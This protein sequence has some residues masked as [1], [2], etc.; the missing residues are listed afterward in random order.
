MAL[1][2]LALYVLWAG[3][4]STPLDAD[5]TL[6][7][8]S[9]GRTS[10]VSVA[11]PFHGDGVSPYRFGPPPS[12]AHLLTALDYL[13]SQPGM[14][15][16]GPTRKA[17]QEDLVELWSLLSQEGAIRRRLLSGL[18]LSDGRAVEVLQQGARAHQRWVG[19]E[20]L[21]RRIAWMA[22]GTPPPGGEIPE[23][24]PLPAGRV[25]TALSTLL[26]VMDLELLHG[27]VPEATLRAWARDLQ[28]DLLL[29]ERIRRVSDRAWGRLGATRQEAAL[30][31]SE[32]IPS[33]QSGDAAL[34]GTAWVLLERL[35]ADPVE[36]P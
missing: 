31:A 18:R 9:G 25:L 34:P 3:G 7:V 11:R 10:T 20:E 16:R 27:E 13:E 5:R 21:R 12:P 2:F 24:A 17:L 30:A 32:R 28:I 33:S 22:L 35:V 8:L 1:A 29:R 26:D 14:A 23:P 6:V 15:P 4:V 19:P 36:V